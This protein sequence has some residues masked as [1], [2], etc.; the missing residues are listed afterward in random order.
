LLDKY[1][2]SIL[3][4]T[5]GRF[6]DLISSDVKPVVETTPE[7]VVE[8]TPEPVV[9]TTPEPVVETTPVVKAARVKKHNKK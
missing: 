5:M 8:T 7:P 6:L 9:E 2:K 3:Y 4:S 1:K